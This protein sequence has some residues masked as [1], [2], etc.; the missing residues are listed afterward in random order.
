MCYT[1]SAAMSTQLPVENA[2]EPWPEHRRGFELAARKLSYDG[3]GLSQWSRRIY[4]DDNRGYDIVE[5]GLD[6]ANCDHCKLK[7]ANSEVAER[8]IRAGLAFA[9]W[10]D[11]NAPPIFIE[12]MK[13]YW[14][15]G[16]PFS[17]EN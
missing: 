5:H 13:I 8:N 16:N 9:G 11:S 12:G 4:W 6:A 2:D 14:M 10:L 15:M 1:V 7:L 3:S 17:G